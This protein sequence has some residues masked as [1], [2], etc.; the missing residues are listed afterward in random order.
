M[1]LFFSVGNKLCLALS[2]TRFLEF[3]LLRDEGSILAL[4]GFGEV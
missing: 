2:S 3:K 1:L 4:K